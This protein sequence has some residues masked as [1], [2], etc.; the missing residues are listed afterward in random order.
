MAA[1][2]RQRKAYL[3]VSEAWRRR[4]R[5]VQSDAATR[6]QSLC[7]CQRAKRAMQLQRLTQSG[8]RIY[9]ARVILRAWLRAR[10]ATRFK[11]LKEAWELEQSME[12]LEDFKR[13]TDVRT[14]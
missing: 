1:Q 5:A 10:D 14:K 11:T 8:K 4:W 2:W 9:A 12:M 13:E 7:R 6:I 3:V